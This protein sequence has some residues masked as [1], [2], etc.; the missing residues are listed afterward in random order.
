MLIWVD[1]EPDSKCSKMSIICGSVALADEKY[2]ISTCH[3][4]G[5]RFIVVIGRFCAPRNKSGTGS[6]LGKPV[7]MKNQ[8]MVQIGWVFF[9]L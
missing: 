3:T 7:K 4:G 1:W 9:C 8:V 6:H 5:P 2:R